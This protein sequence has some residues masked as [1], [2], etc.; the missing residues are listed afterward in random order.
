MLLTETQCSTSK[1]YHITKLCLFL[2]GT[3]ELNGGTCLDTFTVTV[4]TNICRHI[5]QR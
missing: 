1:T 4:S 3:I 2:A 5:K